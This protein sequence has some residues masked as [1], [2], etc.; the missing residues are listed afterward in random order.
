[1]AILYGIIIGALIGLG[2]F[3]GAWTALK[4]KSNPNWK[5]FR[6]ANSNGDDKRV[7]AEIQKG[8]F[9]AFNLE[10]PP[11]TPGE[12]QKRFQRSASEELKHG[13]KR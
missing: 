4:L 1:M 11:E 3:A 2:M 8:G 6:V 13:T 9:T 10:N 7:E 12:M 5:Q